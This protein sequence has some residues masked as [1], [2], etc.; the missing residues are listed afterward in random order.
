LLWRYQRDSAAATISAAWAGRVFAVVLIGLGMITL[1]GGQAIGGLWFL[2]LGWFLL[3]AV[4]QEVAS[5]QLERAFTGVRV[6]DLMARSPVTV[7][8]GLTIAEFAHLIGRWPAHAAYPVVH[9]ARLLGLLSLARAAAVPKQERA[10]VRVAEVMIEGD[11][12]PI[13][14]PDD[15]LVD[16]IRAVQREPGRAVVL[17]GGTGQE[18]VGLLS[19]TDL[20]RA[21]EVAPLRNTAT[22]PAAGTG[23]RGAT[24]GQN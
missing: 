4:H 1:L 9:E 12:V 3:I 20:N 14:H 18:I 24:K 16:A 21:L 10:A 5:A 8:S 6:R 7:E 23:H 13:V 22:C 15:L 2:L 17:D 11:D 19:I